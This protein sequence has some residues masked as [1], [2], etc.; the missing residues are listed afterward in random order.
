MTALVIYATRE[1]QARRIAEHVATS[2]RYGG[3]AADLIDA[4]HIPSS[5]ALAGYSTAI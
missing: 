3:L 1:G 4:A 2:M 5:F